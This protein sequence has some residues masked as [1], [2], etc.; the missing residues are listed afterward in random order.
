MDNVIQS[1]NNW[2]LVDRVQLPGPF[3]RLV[4]NDARLILRGKLTGQRH[5]RFQTESQIATVDSCFDLVGSH[6]H[7]VARN[8]LRDI[9]GISSQ[10]EGTLIL[11]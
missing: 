11:Y 10:N 9:K 7:G 3:L 4:Y 6:Q 2:A 5:D 1:L 8:E